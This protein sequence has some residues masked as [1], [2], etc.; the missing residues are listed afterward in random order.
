MLLIPL[1]TQSTWIAYYMYLSGFTCNRS[2]PT[3]R[4]GATGMGAKVS[5]RGAKNVSE[6][7]RDYIAFAVRIS[8]QPC[9]SLDYRKVNLSV[10]LLRR[11]KLI[12]LLKV[13]SE[14]ERKSGQVRYSWYS[15]RWIAI[16]Y[17]PAR[18]WGLYIHGGFRVCGLIYNINQPYKP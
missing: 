12:K 1:T 17:S 8:H 14:T 15:P 16:V 3:A 11:G 10:F 4:A 7:L 13:Q 9:N 2:S 18:W 6:T 5:E